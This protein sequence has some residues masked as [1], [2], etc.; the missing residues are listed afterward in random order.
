MGHR[1][2]LLCVSYFVKKLTSSHQH[3]SYLVN[4]SYKKELTDFLPSFCLLCFNFTLN[5]LNIIR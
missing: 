3:V 5:Q 2:L 1:T 4:V